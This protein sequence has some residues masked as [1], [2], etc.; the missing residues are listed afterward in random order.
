MKKFNVDFNAELKKIRE[1][2]NIRFISGV[3]LIA[4]GVAF[5]VLSL[6]LWGKKRSLAKAFAAVAAVG[7]IS[8]ALLLVF[9]KKKCCCSCELDDKCDED[10]DIFGDSFNE[11]DVFCNF[12]NDDDCCCGDC[13]EDAD[14]EDE[15]SEA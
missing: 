3:T 11:D 5:G 9:G 14:A 13:E 4:Q 10:D 2:E 8:G 6:I 12:E 1:N 15:G 7:S